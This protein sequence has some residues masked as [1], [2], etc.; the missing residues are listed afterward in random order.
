[1]E[2]KWA[3]S[4]HRARIICVRSWTP[5]VRAVAE[6]EILDDHVRI[7][8]I[9]GAMSVAEKRPEMTVGM[10]EYLPMSHALETVFPS[11][12]STRLVPEATSGG[13]V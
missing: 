8:G 1:M 9:R 2:E 5:Q 7:R 6:V 11:P 12:L 13:T 10:L 4:Y 3:L